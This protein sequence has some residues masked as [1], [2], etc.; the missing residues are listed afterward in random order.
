V[1]RHSSDAGAATVDRSRDGN[2]VDNPQRQGYDSP[3]AEIETLTRESTKSTAVTRAAAGLIPH[4]VPGKRPSDSPGPL[5]P[6][7]ARASGAAVTDVDGNEYVDFIGGQG[8]LLLGHDDDRIVAAI[9]KA[10]AKGY[11]LGETTETRVKLAELLAARFPTIDMVQ[12][13]PSRYHVVREVA[14]LARTFTNRAK[15]IIPDGT[16]SRD[17]FADDDQV[18]DVACTANAM[19]QAVAGLSEAP[20]AVILEPVGTRGGLRLPPDGFLQRVRDLCD[21]REILL[22]FDEAV[23]AFRLAPG[24]ASTLMNVHPDVTCFG[25]SVTGGMG[26]TAYGARRDLMRELAADPRVHLPAM[27]VGD[28]PSFAAGVA[29]LQATA[30]EGFHEFLEERA[31]TFATALSVLPPKGAISLNVE[32]IG[33]I[34]GIEIN[35][36]ASPTTDRCA[37]E[38]TFYETLLNHGVLF[39]TGLR[40]CLYVSAAHQD[41]HISRAAGALDRALT[42]IHDMMS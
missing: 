28:E 5:V 32:R 9:T 26:V 6:V 38:T 42:A 13:A 10:A 23:T 17:A 25:T 30:E 36:G 8:S 2:R 15:V 7:L 12:F 40:F 31:T 11:A 20:A 29:F 33:S 24:G 1:V 35:T 41:D 39:P 3:M 34:I 22:V 4:R 18:I 27:D 14:R 37:I 21:S 16:A 19:E